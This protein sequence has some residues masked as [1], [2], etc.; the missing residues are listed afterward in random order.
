M[1]H[2][3]ALLRR[4]TGGVA[5]AATL[6]LAAACAS[7]HAGPYAPLDETRRDTALAE[8]LTR[9]AADLITSDPAQAEALL[10]DALA[11]DLYHGPAHNNLGVLYLKMEPSRLYEAAGEFEWARKLMPGHPDPRLNLAYTLEL[12]GRSDDA[13]NGYRAA[14]EVDP[15]HLPT[16]QALARLQVRTGKKDAL[17]SKLLQNIVFRTTDEPWR[18][19]AR[20]QVI[21]LETAS[22]T[23]DPSVT[24]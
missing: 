18:Q 3:P 22:K 6:T 7:N 1:I 12:A 9:R 11:A 2:T 4:I 19:W 24:R 20:G 14:L 13:I 23:I 21:R 10:R 15:N 16:I 17:T 8:R 5:L